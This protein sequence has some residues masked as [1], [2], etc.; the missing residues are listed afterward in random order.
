MC[1]RYYTEGNGEMH[2]M[3]M[4]FSWKAIILQS[5]LLIYKVVMLLLVLQLL[6][7]HL[8]TKCDVINGCSC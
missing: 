6:R 2:S 7:L 8:L 1:L 4:D 3:Q 5:S